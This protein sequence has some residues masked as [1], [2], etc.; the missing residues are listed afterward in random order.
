MQETRFTGITGSK[1][2]ASQSIAF[3]GLNKNTRYVVSF[4]R[5]NNPTS[6]LIR[7]CFKTRGEWSVNPVFSSPYGGERSGCFAVGTTR[8]DVTE[9]FCDGTRG[10]NRIITSSGDRT[11]LGC[12]DTS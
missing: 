11:T 10:G 2:V 12:A 6:P 8:Q 4:Y 7:R 9:C 5:L 1:S 3:S